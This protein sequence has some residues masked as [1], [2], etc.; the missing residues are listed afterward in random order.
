M[1]RRALAILIAWFACLELSDP[2]FCNPRAPFSRVRRSFD[3]CSW[4][5]SPISRRLIN[6]IIQ[7]ADITP[8]ANGAR[9]GPTA[10]SAGLEAS[11]DRAFKEEEPLQHIILW[12]RY[13]NLIHRL[14]VVE[15]PPLFL[16]S[17][18][19][20]HLEALVPLTVKSRKPVFNDTSQCHQYWCGNQEKWQKARHAN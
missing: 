2:M 12:T 9:H 15:S 5:F 19:E 13:C 1:Y 16:V 6:A 3:G 17:T 10:R 20:L 18:S 11:V 8:L 4:A 7:I 14:A